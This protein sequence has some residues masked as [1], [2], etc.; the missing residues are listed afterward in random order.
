M[1]DV[2]GMNDALTWLGLVAVCAL[3]LGELAVNLGIRQELRVE[4]RPENSKTSQT[5]GQ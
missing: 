1:S 4:R 5:S 2:A 3:A